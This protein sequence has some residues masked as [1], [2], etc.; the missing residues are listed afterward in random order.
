[1]E[2]APSSQLLNNASNTWRI[3]TSWTNL[4]MFLAVRRKQTWK[5]LM[6]SS[7]LLITHVNEFVRYRGSCY[8]Q[9]Y[10]TGAPG[11]RG[12][13]AQSAHSALNASMISFRRELPKWQVAC[14]IPFKPASNGS[15]RLTLHTHVISPRQ[16]SQPWHSQ[17]ALLCSQ[18]PG[19]E[20]FE[21]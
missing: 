11:L 3:K 4:W 6:N 17:A 12:P 13:V 14:W 21:W 18:L 7:S 1:M 5:G 19:K 20:A 15:L 8:L 2:A 9:Q 10:Q 16:V